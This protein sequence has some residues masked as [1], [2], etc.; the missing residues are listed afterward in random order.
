VKYPYEGVLRNEFDDPAK[1]F[2]RG[3]QIFDNSP[4]GAASEAVKLKMLKSMSGALGVNITS[5]TCLTT[6]ID[7]LKQQGVTDLSK[8]S[9]LWITTALGFFFRIL[10]YIALSLGSKNKRR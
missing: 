4:L 7:I 8:W 5:S 9:C 10:F 2:V 1:C 3:T 6:G